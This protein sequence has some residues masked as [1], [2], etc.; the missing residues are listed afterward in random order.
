MFSAEVWL[1]IRAIFLV[2][3]WKTEVFAYI[4]YACSVPVV[5]LYGMNGS[6]AYA[7]E[8]GV[9]LAS[10]DAQAAGGVEIMRAPGLSALDAG[11]GAYGAAEAASAG[12]DLHFLIKNQA[13]I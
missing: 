12:E 11:D 1:S 7:A 2:K 5:Y 9:F 3:K 8:T 10:G 13:E 6:V 4:S